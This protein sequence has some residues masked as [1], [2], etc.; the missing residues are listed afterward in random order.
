MRL[1]WPLTVSIVACAS[2]CASGCASASAPAAAS[3]SASASVR[4]ATPAD[5]DQLRARVGGRLIEVHSVVEPCQAS[6]DNPAC[7][8]V[9]REINNPFF[10]EDQPGATQS[11]GWFGAWKPEVGA[12]AV[13]AESADDVAAAVD[14]ARDHGLRLAVKGTGHDYLG[15]SNAP[16]SLLVWTHAMRDV[17]VQD[18]FVPQ[19]CSVPGV[20]AVSVGAGTRWIE[21]YDAVTVKHHRYVQGGGCTSVGAAGGFLQGGGFGSWSKKY[22]VA[23]AGLLEAEVVT[24]DGKTR[25]ANACQNADLFWALRGGGGGTFGVVTRATL[26]T[27]PLPDRF[28]W[29]NGTL[30]AKSD[31]AF[32]E[33]LERF[34]AFYR[35]SMS[36]ERWGEQVRVRGANE[37][38]VSLAFEGM[39]AHD[40]EELWRPL[41]AWVEARPESYAIELRFD[42]APPDVMWSYEVLHKV[43]PED[44][45]SDDRPGESPAHYIWSGDHDQAYT[46]WYAYQSRW[47]PLSLFDDP[48]KLA[49]ALFEASRHWSVGIHFNKGQAGASPDAVKRGRETAMNPAVFDAAALAII[50]ASGDGAPGVAGHEPNAVEAKDHAARVTAAMQAIR[51]VTPDAGSYVNETDYFEPEWQRAFWGGNY[52]RLLEVKRK[53]DP[54][55]VFRCHHCVGSE[56]R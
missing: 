13:A 30:R 4:P 8:A 22:G 54:R 36:D 16:G 56:E 31:A 33:L 14:F 49:G 26:M 41:R 43:A 34:V 45:W 52:A 27:H 40:A 38:V 10:L 29:V 25:I 11:A 46:Y 55:G 12:Y 50:A 7:A 53:Y 15:R 1:A 18:A 47:L 21:A 2:A 19:G 35:A 5:W 9:A 20:P 32:R 3:A 28:G 39:T 24:A 6:F 44:I 42:D 23:A 37:L 17:K 51:A 48:K